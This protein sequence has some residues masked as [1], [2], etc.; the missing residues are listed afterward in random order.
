M[1]WEPERAH[2][3]GLHLDDLPKTR[4]TLEAEG[5]NVRVKF[6]S[7]SFSLNSL[8]VQLALNRLRRSAPEPGEDSFV[9]LTGVITDPNRVARLIPGQWT[10]G[11]REV[12][13]RALEVLRD[14]VA[15]ATA[16]GTRAILVTGPH[17]RRS[18][19]RPEEAVA[20]DAIAAVALEEGGT[21]IQVNE[22]TH[23]ELLDPALYSDPTH[24]NGEGAVIYSD[25]LARLLATE[26]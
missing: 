23:P 5:F 2:V 14:F 17:Y 11:E 13:P 12:D 6:L 18:A 21:F 26:L 1:S 20:L 25:I 8:V 9:P 16:R 24:L 22:R 15:S 4:A 3:A 19:V 10:S 7:R